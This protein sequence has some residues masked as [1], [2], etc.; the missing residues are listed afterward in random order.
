MVRRT[1]NALGHQTTW[2]ILFIVCA[3]AFAVACTVALPLATAM[4]AGAR[5]VVSLPQRRDAPFEVHCKVLTVRGMAD[6]LYCVGCEFVPSNA[7]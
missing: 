3:I 4:P 7:A 1:C 2:R 6:E 5:I